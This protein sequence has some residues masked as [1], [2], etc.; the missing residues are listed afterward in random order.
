MSGHSRWANI[1]HKKEKADKQK[2]KIFSRI[3]KEI[4]SAVKQKGPDPR[5]NSKL[6]IAI[7][8]AKAANI[9][10]DNIERN[11]KKASHAD[12]QDYVEMTYEFYGHGGVGIIVE[13]MTDNKNRLAADFR[14]AINKC[15]GTIA[16]PG[17]V[18]FNFEK[19]GIFKILKKD[20]LED[21]L[22]TIVSDAGA[23]DFDTTDEIYVVVTEPDHFLKVKEALEKNKIKVQ[24]ATLEMVPKTYITCSQG[25]VAANNKLIEWLE[26]TDDVDALYH[27]MTT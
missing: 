27:N 18:S 10:N 25:D 26:N 11:I 3:M 4:I 24:E 19:K 12:Q 21:E 13:A 6:K 22:F 17:S 8:K 5:A 2:G 20:A 7:E 9:P 14:I 16:N 15:G 23:E 1:K